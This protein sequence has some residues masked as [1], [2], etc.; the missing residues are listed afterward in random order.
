MLRINFKHIH[1]TS[2]TFLNYIAGTSDLF[3]SSHLKTEIILRA[4]LNAVTDTSSALRVLFNQKEYYFCKDGITVL[5]LPEKHL[6]M[7]F[8]LLHTLKQYCLTIRKPI[9][10]L[11]EILLS[12]F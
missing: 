5:H 2:D 6:K 12:L 4:A 10:I 8:V 11:K 3:I 7:W 1:K 9:H